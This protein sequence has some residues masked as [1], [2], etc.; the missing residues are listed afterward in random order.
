MDE[1]LEGMEVIVGYD[2]ES[3]EDVRAEIAPLV[4]NHY[5]EVVVYPDI[6]LNVDEEM[7]QKIDEAGGLRLFTARN[8][9][10][11]LIGYCI[12]F[13]RH[14][15]HY[16]DSFQAFQDVLFIQKEYRGFG[17]KFIKWCDE[18]LSEEK[19]QVVFHGVKAA[20]NYGSLLE[21]VGYKL[22]DLLYSRRLD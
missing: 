13:V 17:K 19:V 15:L 11:D 8:T 18:R 2:L 22:S 1:G 4:L 20:H 10:G 14:H 6:K 21:D 12:F 5:H 3:Y 16:M 7:Y 9:A